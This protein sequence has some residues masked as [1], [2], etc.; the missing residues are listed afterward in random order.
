M[1]RVHRPSIRPFFD[2]LE[3]RRLLSGSLPAAST[4][5]NSK[6]PL[7]DFV[8]ANN[9]LLF[10][11]DDGA[12]GPELWRADGYQ[13]NTALVKD[14]RPGLLGAL[15]ATPDRP[16][17]GDTPVIPQGLFPVGP[18][19]YFPADDGIHGLELWRTD[20]TAAG[21]LLVRD[22]NPGA[23]GSAPDQF[24]HIGAQLYFTT[25]VGA[26]YQLWRSDGT[27]VGTVRIVDLGTMTV[28]SI[29]LLDGVVYF[30]RTRSYPA[31]DELWK[32][33]GTSAGT[34]RVNLPAGVS[35]NN[36]TLAVLGHR[37]IVLAT[38]GVNSFN[39]ATGTATLLID[40]ANS[41]EA[42]ASFTPLATI[43]G[44]LIFRDS[45]AIADFGTNFKPGFGLYAIDGN[46]GGVAYLGAVYANKDE[47]PLFQFVQSGNFLYFSNRSE[48]HG[49]SLF[50][51]PGNLLQ[52]RGGSEQIATNRWI[53]AISNLV[54]VGDVLYFCDQ[55]SLWTSD[56]TSAGT[57]RV[58]QLPNYARMKQSVA[59]G[60]TL[61]FTSSDSFS[62][63]LW[64]YTP[65]SPRR[66]LRHIVA[67]TPDLRLANDRLTI[68]GMSRDD[69]V[70]LAAD[71]RHDRLTINWNDIVTRMPLS[72][73]KSVLING[74]DGHDYLKL[75]GP[76]PAATLVGGAGSD[77][78][79]GGD[80]DDRLD[81]GDLNDRL[82]G[83]AGND[84]LYGDAGDDTLAGGLGADIC[85]G[86]AGADTADYAD[87]HTYVTITP[88]GLD[89]D[90][91]RRERDNVLPDVERL[92]GG[93][94]SDRLDASTRITSVTLIGNAGNDTLIGSAA[95]DSLEGDGGDDSLLA[96]AGNDLLFGDQ[97][98]FKDDDGNDYLRGGD[99]NDTLYDGLGAD[100]LYGDN[101][102]DFFKASDFAPYDHLFGGPG[103]NTGEYLDKGDENVNISFAYNPSA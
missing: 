86:G 33:D 12:H 46:P 60:G 17:S 92:I 59:V 42:G 68:N 83:G 37:L 101:G 45:V 82:F 90:G 99:G 5:Y 67:L 11:N 57:T 51:S 54:D 87:R 47:D 52:N 53:G 8:N 65:S 31:P 2:P 103:Q 55:E 15:P 70:Q 69:F 13:E 20:G 77:Y 63:E 98:S 19:T 58:F 96:N 25:K 89:D 34:A 39:P 38:E 66:K 71:P 35:L 76:V 18:T 41:S 73:V 16:L 30:I 23:Q 27:T 84:E 36:G 10:I 40:Y 80:L 43:G 91:A 50:R 21:T 56:G 24:T 64:T 75:I 78:L 32:T 62:S 26:N 44:R 29:I 48:I 94:G 93:A 61:F 100:T 4:D 1:N 97:A 28:K 74:N 9:T 81:G 49:D 85:H 22:L 95:A 102:N 6:P 14:I 3:P 79:V 72:A 88:D 7:W